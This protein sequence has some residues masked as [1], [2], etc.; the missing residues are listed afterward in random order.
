MAFT[1]EFFR[2]DFE[3]DADLLELAGVSKIDRD[4]D[5]AAFEK[6]GPGDWS[7]KFDGMQFFRLRRHAGFWDKDAAEL[8]KALGKLIVG[9]H[10]ICDAYTFVLHGSPS[11]SEKVIS[12]IECWFGV[13][14]RDVEPERLKLGD[15]LASELRELNEWTKL[16]SKPLHISKIDNHLV[17]VSGTPN[18]V[19]GDKAP[20]DGLCEALFGIHWSYILYARPKSS[21]WVRDWA[22][23]INILM[24]NRD[25]NDHADDRVQEAWYTAIDLL[26]ERASEGRQTGLWDT[27]IWFSAP[28]RETI[29][30]GRS[31]LQTAFGGVESA[32][33]PIRITETVQGPAT[34]SEPWPLTAQQLAVFSC[35]PAHQY[36]GYEIADYVRFGVQAIEV[37]SRGTKTPRLEIGDILANGRNTGNKLAIELNDLTAHTLIVGITG[38]GKTN[39]CFQILAQLAENDIP[40]MVIESAKSEYR[41][42][43]NDVRFKRR[44][45]VY[46]VGNETI[47]P[48]RLNP[49]EVPDGMLVQVHIE[50][51]KQSLIGAFAL[52]SPMPEVLEQ[53]IEEIYKD[54]GWDLSTNVN[55]RAGQT[56]LG[57]QRFP[58]LDDLVEKIN[59]LVE[60]TRYPDEVKGTLRSGLVLRLDRLRKSP[61]NGPMY[62]TSEL[63]PD[64]KLFEQTCIIELET[65][66]DPAKA[67]FMGLILTRLYEYHRVR[68]EA[69]RSGKGDGRSDDDESAKPGALRH[70]ILIEEAHRLLSNVPAAQ[71]A[72]SKNPKAEAV[73]KFSNML[74]EIRS[75]GEGFILAEQSPTKLVSDALKNT[76][77]KIIHRVVEKDERNAAGSS[78]ALAEDQINHLARLRSGEAV[79]YAERLRSPVLVKVLLSPAKEK[80]G[81]SNDDLTQT[82]VFAPQTVIQDLEGTN[83]RLH[84]EL[85][86]SFDFCFRSLLASRLSLL[87]YEKFVQKAQVALPKAPVVEVFY[88]LLEIELRRRGKPF[89]SRFEMMDAA[90]DL[91][92]KFAVAWEASPPTP[93]D[94]ESEA[95]M[96]WRELAADIQRLY[97]LPDS[98][99]RPF[100]GCEACRSP[101]HYHY[102]VGKIM[103]SASERDAFLVDLVTL[104]ELADDLVRLEPEDEK[105]EQFE[106]QGS[107]VLN[108]LL[109]RLESAS[110]RIVPFFERPER[111]AA[112]AFCYTVAN[113]N[114]ARDQ[115]PFNFAKNSSWFNELFQSE[116]RRRSS[117]A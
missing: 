9:L 77:L 1:K 85:L 29:I 111:F 76:N 60:N 112:A 105:R 97:D 70:V 47:S 68:Q 32:P 64:K 10:G 98:E 53:A 56:Y 24:S 106:Q 100:A 109:H 51:V 33:D 57:S 84:R 82:T 3:K 80:Q 75:Y 38:S 73:E 104:R 13:R 17:R 43:L 87:L 55:T 41:E 36:S 8:V 83:P 6:P 71:T 96:R 46:T 50:Y 101:C 27:E 44:P 11:S 107:K 110:Q 37:A 99:T 28:S 54:C 67:L 22:Q 40:F 35:P 5:G 31:L 114:E 49:F 20:A 12:E 59:F 91:G 19:T 115:L 88:Y 42:L 25:Q 39:T 16:D 74:A 21:Q 103:P 94:G 93:D 62:N 34:V 86:E 61:G 90:M 58:T 102:D 92:R 30:R 26:R 48:M 72:D 117:D 65:L 81:V 113:M 116:F 23:D 7:A 78:M 18:P 4:A 79:V 14:I 66:S 95:V 2:D 15:L 89:R 52:P 63:L 108:R 69:V 45:F